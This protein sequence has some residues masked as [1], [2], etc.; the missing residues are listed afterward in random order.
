MCHF[1][2]RAHDLTGGWCREYET[3]FSLQLSYHIFSKY[4]QLLT[5]SG[6][7]E[8][9]ILLFCLVGRMW[10]VITSRVFHGAPRQSTSVR[11]ETQLQGACWERTVS[12]IWWATGGL[13]SFATSETSPSHSGSLPTEGCLAQEA[14][15]EWLGHL[16]WDRGGAGS[17]VQPWE[18]LTRYD[19][20]L[21]HMSGFQCLC[22]PDSTAL[23]NMPVSVLKLLLQM[24]YMYLL[25]KKQK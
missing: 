19:A 22:L 9:K 20:A 21:A 24:Q 13:L 23:H 8:V 12:R 4:K 6:I 17:N 3:L 18:L 7:L 5:V 1:F 15:S 16:P 2:P 14:T 25:F 10:L 11:W